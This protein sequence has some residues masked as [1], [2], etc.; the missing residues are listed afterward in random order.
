MEARGPL[1]VSEVLV[2][3]NVIV[4][5]YDPADAVK[6][7]CAVQIMTFLDADPGYL[8]AQ[9]MGEFFVVATRRIAV[10][11]TVDEALERNRHYS[12]KWTVLPTTSAIVA[13]AVRGVRDHAMSYWDAQL[14]AAARLNAIPVLLSEDLSDGS[15]IEGVRFANPFKTGFSLQDWL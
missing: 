14:W 6:H 9:I 5:S 2:D 7:A 13:E 11:L 12:S 10:P 3:T 15:V 1:R 4:Y 8:T